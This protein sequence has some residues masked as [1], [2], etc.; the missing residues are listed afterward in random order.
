MGRQILTFAIVFIVLMFIM[1]KACTAPS[2]KGGLPVE[3]PDP[4][5]EGAA[6]LKQGGTEVVLGP[7]GSV[8][9]IT[10]GGVPVM[11]P[12]AASRRPFHLFLRKTENALAIPDAGWKGEDVPGG[13]K[14]VYADEKLTVERTVRLAE[15][16]CSLAFELRIKGLPAD[17]NVF[18]LTGASGIELAAEGAE[19]PFAFTEVSGGKPRIL[20]F[21][22]LKQS[23]EAGERPY[24]WA[25]EPGA[26]ERLSRF[27]LFGHAYCLALAD[28]PQV[29]KLFVDVYRSNRGEGGETDE[30]ETWLE[31]VAK[32]G[33]Y[34]GSFALRWT[35]RTEATATFPASQ[36]RP[37]RSHIL[38]DGTF[39]VVLTDRGAAILEMWLKKF[40]T[41]AGE[42]PSET[43]WIP[44][45]NGG[46][47]EGDRALT[48]VAEGHGCDLGHEIWDMAPAE[49]GRSV[50]FTLTAP[51]GWKFLKRLTLPEGD[52]YDLGVE[53]GVEAPAGASAS[54]ALLGLIGPSGSYIVDSYRGIIG[55]EVPS[56]FIL[57]RD[58]EDES[59]SIEKLKSGILDRTYSEERRGTFRA[60]GTRGTYFVCAL[61]SEDPKNAVTSAIGKWIQL[62]RAQPRADREPPTK[63]SM[64]GRVG[65]ALPLEGGRA[66]QRFRLYAGPNELSALKAL[67]IGGSVNFGFFGTIGRALMWLMKGLHGLVGSFGIAIMLMTVIVRALLAPISFKTQLSM[68]R[69]GKRIQKIKPLLDE[70][71]KKHAKDPQRMNQERM[72]VMKEHGVGLPL[73]CLMMFFQIPIWY[74][75]FQALRVEFALRHQ[76][77]LWA[78]DLSMPDRL[79]G[80]PFF[81][82]WFNLLPILMLV[83]WVL[84]QKLAPTPGSSD[85]PQVKMQ[86]KMMKFM[87]YVFFFMLYNYAAALAL[88]MC[89]SSCWTI[90]ES[91][92]VRRAIAKLG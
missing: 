80:L 31:L 40:S 89:M 44:I 33:D 84:Q 30:A 61:V 62:D 85:D 11:R 37:G 88:Y 42:P 34:S 2:A 17:D 81:P 18:G 8:A 70:I 76:P 66:S 51:D 54:Q 63:D 26:D 47:P 73:G 53:V 38:E 22:S 79:F 5:P 45:L 28:L 21:T 67:E 39:R 83:L 82:H 49:D 36:T 74:G 56:T 15:D 3:T 69:Y 91:K 20:S 59:K 58:G 43:T 64:L 48:L 52:R 57:D 86:M 41:V 29:A 10:A 77:F 16:G 1:P 23:R 46:T 75:L 24:A 78:H 14:F 72:R 60:V 55:A 25:E 68:Q 90:A 71:Q 7:D 19:P 27:G 9:S 6:V 12:V 13:R 35:P 32:D 92:L 50:L 65:L 87:P 4:L